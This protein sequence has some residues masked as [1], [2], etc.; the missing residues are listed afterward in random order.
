MLSNKQPQNL[1]NKD[2]LLTH[3]AGSACFLHF[4][5]RLKEGPLSGTYSSLAKS[6]QMA[7]PGCLDAWMPVREKYTPI[8]R[9][10]EN[11]Q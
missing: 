8:S 10:T 9:R 5:S 2:L 4:E 7:G 3:I 6:S 1:R 11:N